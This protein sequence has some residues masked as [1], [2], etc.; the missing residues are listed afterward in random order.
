MCPPSATRK[1]GE[2]APFHRAR[3][4]GHASST[5]LIL[6]V[7]ERKQRKQRCCQQTTDH[8]S[9]GE[10]YAAGRRK[11]RSKVWIGDD[12]TTQFYP[13]LKAFP[14]T[15]VCVATNGIVA[16]QPARHNL[17]G[18]DHSMPAAKR[19]GSPCGRWPARLSALTPASHGAGDN[20]Q[21]GPTGAGYYRLDY[22]GAIVHASQGWNQ[23]LED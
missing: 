7:D 14:K 13:W 4:E 6:G 3:Q 22:D 12:A 21:N 1:S 5:A 8:A 19:P 18:R 11:G 2:R 15:P 10:C 17:Q 16:E 20:S 9:A 23:G